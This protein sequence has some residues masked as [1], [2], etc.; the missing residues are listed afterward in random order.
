MNR[1]SVA[2]SWLLV[3][4][5]LLLL[6]SVTLGLQQLVRQGHL[7]AGVG[8]G[9]DLTPNLQ[10]FRDPTGDLDITAV[11][12]HLAAGH[13]FRPTPE[14]L[15]VGYS[16]D[17]IW[18]TVEFSN[19]GP[20]PVTRYLEV[21]PP[22]AADVRLYY[23]AAQG[24]FRELR[25]G[26]QV[27]V[28]ERAISA[29]QSVFP[30]EFAPGEHRRLFV[31]LQS[32]NAIVVDLRLWEPT[33]FLEATR[34][35]DLLNGLQFGALLLFALYAF[36]AAGA[37]RDRPHFYFGITLLS[38]A[39]Y[40]ITIMQYGYQ[41]LWPDSPDWSLRGPGVILAMAVFGLGM[42]VA[43]LL[44]TRTRM[45]R[46]DLSL[47]GIALLA[48]CYIPGLLVGDYSA[49]VQWLN[50]LMLLQLLLT[51]A[52]TLQA[53]FL[54]YRG[55]W[56]LLGAFLLLWFTSLLRVGQILGLVPHLLLAEYSQG[57]SMV[58]GGLLMALIQADRVRRLNAEREDAR[59]ALLRA[60][61]TAREEAETAVAER[62]LELVRAKEAAE[63][64][65]RAKSAFLTQLSHELRTPL[66]SILGYSGL[67]R[68]E[69]T[70]SET[71]RRLDTIRRSGLHL[72]QL[73]DGLLDYARGE[74]GR[75]KLELQPLRLRDFLESV[76]DETRELAAQ[77][78]MV[79]D[80][81]VDPGLPQGLR[82][83]GTRLRQVLINLVA[84]AC[85]HSQGHRI[86]VEA[87]PEPT[88]SPG[89]VRLSLAVRDDGI[90]I[91]PA[92]RERIF[93]PFE[94]GQDGSSKGLGLGLAI[95]R[96]LVALMGG[97]LVLEEAREG[98]CFRLTL[99]TE[100]LDLP[101]AGPAPRPAAARHF[102]GPSR[103]I[104]VV[105]DQDDRRSALATM[106]LALGFEVEQAADAESALAGPA[107]DVIHLV[108]T[109]RHLP[110]MSSPAFLLE[111][112]RRDWRQPFVLVAADG[113]GPQAGEEGFA[114]M[115]ARPVSPD[116]LAA[117]AGRLLGLAWV[118][119]PAPP[120]APPPTMPARPPAPQ[121]ADLR[122]AAREGRLSDIDDWLEQVEAQYPETASFAAAVRGAARRLDLAAIVAMTEES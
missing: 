36:V 22:R 13:F 23:R 5:L 64:S 85:R 61:V 104:L 56:L 10:V 117:V 26:L 9:L 101:T 88:H 41:Y 18:A 60:Q 99:E 94:Q 121:L 30:L 103:R 28:R 19:R 43:G 37:M 33:V 29:R 96:Q 114:A 84:N 97:E 15:A 11:S 98:S 38:S 109:E 52:A 78:K 53:L 83:D 118:E 72:L 32:A 48:P 67:M 2:R 68:D 79:L 27:P 51:I 59:R 58:V 91:P 107:Q 14:E 74:A 50:Y 71:Q 69:A 102:A 55:A 116:A 46:W 86:V 1:R 80:L 20:D 39:L 49:W 45:P 65:S 31:R 82:L 119:R 3:P 111:A 120:E 108:I 122:R 16:R 90:G 87:R 81:V 12:A 112:R 4:L 73:I 75:L 93:Q 89:R 40:D 77:Q 8:H 105:D 7:L 24:E 35:V 100:A 25:A 34:R 21:G 42:L 76:V 57:W 17:A 62:T 47:R 6:A 115:L 70:D 95:S 66:H 106:L 113:G 63:A 54:G 92:D 44:E 110:G